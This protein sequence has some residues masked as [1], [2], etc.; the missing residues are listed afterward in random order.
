[1]EFGQGN[2]PRWQRRARRLMLTELSRLLPL[3][4]KSPL[5]IAAFAV[6][7]DEFALARWTSRAG[8]TYHVRIDSHAPLLNRPRF[9]LV[10]LL[11]T[12]ETRSTP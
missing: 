12:G 4:R 5:E 10:S 7:V 1:M 11:L 2:V 9:A 6:S 3:E 8:K